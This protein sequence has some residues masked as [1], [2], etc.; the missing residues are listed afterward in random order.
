[1]QNE[2]IT[3]IVTTYNRPELISAAVINCLNQTYKNIEVIVVDDNGLGQPKQI[4]TRKELEEFITTGKVKYFAL[5]QNQG[6][7]IARNFGAEQSSGQFISFFDEDD[8]WTVDKIETQYEL[9]SKSEQDVAMVLCG[10]KSIIEETRKEYYRPD[11]SKLE[12]DTYMKLLNSA[13]SFATP[14]PLIKREAFFKVGKFSEG[15]PS[16]QDL[17]LGIRLCKKYKLKVVNKICLIS[18]VH[19]GERISTNHMAKIKGFRYILDNY[20][21]DLTKEGEIQYWERILM[22]SF[23]GRY[24]EYGHEGALELKKLNAFKFKYRCFYLGIKYSFIRRVLIGY[25]F[26]NKSLY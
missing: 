23:Y 10:Q 16:A 1:M 20:K 22:H 18:K 3:V 26:L 7:C 25:L 4:E 8:E 9:L 14:N 11:F 21:E 5:E 24:T 19:K 12:S 17:E 6:A 15:L 2:L 13:I